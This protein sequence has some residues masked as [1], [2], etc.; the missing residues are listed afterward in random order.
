MCLLSRISTNF[1]AIVEER[2]NLVP[3]RILAHCL[4]SHHWHMVL[5]QRAEGDLARFL[6]RIS[7]THR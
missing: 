6:Q 4:M 5:Y 2:L 1:I 3:M 7:L